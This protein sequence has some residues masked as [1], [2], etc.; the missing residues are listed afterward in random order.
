MGDQGVQPSLQIPQTLNKRNIYSAH[1]SAWMVDPSGQS[2][3]SPPGAH[4]SVQ[5]IFY[6]YTTG[7]EISQNML[8]TS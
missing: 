5:R 2:T 6:R 3:L 1:R 7:H 4:Q 8:W